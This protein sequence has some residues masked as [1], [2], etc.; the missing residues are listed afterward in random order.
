[1]SKLQAPFRVDHVGSF[2]R[3]KEL[4]EAKEKFVKGEITRE[5]LTAVED[6]AIEKLVEQQKKA[7]LKGFTDGEFRRQYWHL[8]FFWGLNGVEHTQAKIGYQS[9]MKSQNLTQQ[10]SLE[11]SL[12]KIT[13]S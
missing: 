2:L 1:M 7:G 11:K 5:E 9:T 12:V 13:H 8:D 4:V 10:M 3:P 6:K